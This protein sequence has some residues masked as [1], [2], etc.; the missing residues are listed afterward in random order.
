MSINISFNKNNFSLNKLKLPSRYFYF[1][2]SE[3][4]IKLLT[5]GE[6]I[7]P[8]DRIKMVFG[9]INSSCIFS[10]ESATKVYPSSKEYGVSSVDIDLDN[11]NCEFMNDELI[12]YKKS[13]LIQ[14]L[15]VNIRKNSTLF[16]VDILSQ[17]RSFENFDFTS[18]IVRNRFYVDYELEYYENYN[19]TSSLFKDYLKR[20]NTKQ[21]I[22]AKI[23]IK[24]DNNEK[25]LDILI[26]NKFNTFAY[27]HSKKMLIGVVSGDN[28]GKLK[29][30]LKNIWDMY[31][32]AINKKPFNLGKG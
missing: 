2:E 15:S 21:N 3:N 4:Y 8:R 12:L 29:N 13:R 16:Y 19:I 23:Y 9:L 1:N 18:M 27:T 30:K 22:Y 17:G 24:I 6:G 7:F 26:K 32:L 5:I 28:M 31:R 20:H 10:T 25:I 11:S 14:F